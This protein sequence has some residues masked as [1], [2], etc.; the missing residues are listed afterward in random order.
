MRPPLQGSNSDKSMRPCSCT[1]L[2]RYL[3]GF[4]AAL[5]ASSALAKACFPSRKHIE[6]GSNV[7]SLKYGNP[8]SFLRWWCF[9]AKP[10]VGL[11]ATLGR[12]LESLQLHPKT[13]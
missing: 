5:Y 11:T 12:L 1:T 4:F 9:M 3:P 2:T 8:P 13:G 6:I 10:P 7:A